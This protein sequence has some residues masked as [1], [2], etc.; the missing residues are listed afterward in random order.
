MSSSSSSI[1]LFSLF[2]G[3]FFIIPKN[4]KAQLPPSEVS[5]LNKQLAQV[6]QDLKFLSNSINQTN[7]NLLPK[8]DE[9]IEQFNEVVY[10]WNI[11]NNLVIDK[12]KVFESL[13]NVSIIKWQSSLDLIERIEPD[14][15]KKIENISNHWKTT[16]SLVESAVLSAKSIE[17]QWKITNEKIAAVTSSGFAVGYGALIGL[18]MSVTAVFLTG[19]FSLGKYILSNRSNRKVGHY[20]N[21]Q[22]AGNVG[23][24]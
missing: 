4:I 1:K 7:Q 10:Q 20:E 3:L 8:I 23:G 19:T 13:W 21:S 5:G 2:V 14:L 24:V 11:S 15:I 12:S 22:F 9:L 16:N 6:S 18:G 17:D